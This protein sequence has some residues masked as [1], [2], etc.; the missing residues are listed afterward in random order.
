[1]AIEVKHGADPA[2]TLFARYGGAEGQAMRRALEGFLKAR[3]RMELQGR[4]EDFRRELTGISHEQDIE[5]MLISQDMRYAL[6]ERQGQYDLQRQRIRNVGRQQE[7]A[8]RY[9]YE[10]G[11]VDYQFTAEQRDRQEKIRTALGLL[12]H[13]ETLTPEDRQESRRELIYQY[14][15]I[16]KVPKPKEAPI[17]INELVQYHE[18]TGASF[19]LD[20]STGKRTEVK[21]PGGG[22]TESE[23]WKIAI[24][25]HTLDGVLDVDAAKKMVGEMSSGGEGPGGG[26]QTDYGLRPDGTQKGG[27]FFGP[28]QGRGPMQGY[29]MSEYSIGVDFDGKEMDIP[30]MVPTLTGSELD[31][32]LRGV[33]TPAIKD[34]AVGHAKKRLRAGKPVFAEEDEQQSPAE[35]QV[36]TKL[37]RLKELEE[38]TTGQISLG[39]PEQ[40]DPKKLTNISAAFSAVKLASFILEEHRKKPIARKKGPRSGTEEFN[41]RSGAGQRY[42]GERREWEEK[43]QKL[44]S[45]IEK[46]KDSLEG[47]QKEAREIRGDL[48]ATDDITEILTNLDMRR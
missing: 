45:A 20:P 48:K 40:I 4:S 31:S 24:D 43:E 17:D 7:I 41:P 32:V 10:R 27:G 18:G 34:K 5:K 22:L 3:E 38:D 23:K 44:I 1:M 16:E 25:A 2:S 36:Q 42:R 39:R 30:T 15:G 26:V 11:M 12:E 9:D 8:D 37:E 21:G 28:L 35:R 47:M 29:D 13:D 6:S 19:L 46:Y 33:V 14:A